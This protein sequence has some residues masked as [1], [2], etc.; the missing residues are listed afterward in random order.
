MKK[1][2][3][4]IAKNETTLLILCIFIVLFGGILLINY[5]LLGAIIII[6]SLTLSGIINLC[7]QYKNKK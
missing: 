4:I 2:I 1:I 3:F 5:D 6:I 7:T